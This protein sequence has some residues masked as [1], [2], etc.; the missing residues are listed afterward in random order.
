MLLCSA[1]TSAKYLIDTYYRSLI[2]LGPIT[3]TAADVSPLCNLS[4]NYGQQH[5]R[6]RGVGNV[7]RESLPVCMTRFMSSHAIMALSQQICFKCKPYSHRWSTTNFTAF[8]D[9]SFSLYLLFFS[10]PWYRKAMKLVAMVV[11]IITFSLSEVTDWNTPMGLWPTKWDGIDNIKVGRECGRV[12]LLH[13]GLKK[14]EMCWRNR[15]PKCV[16]W[17]GQCYWYRS[18]R[19][20]P[21][22]FVQKRDQPVTWADQGLA[23]PACHYRLPPRV[24]GLL[25]AFMKPHGE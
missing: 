2:L 15:V 22:E 4:Y 23:G 21:V 7:Q 9:G 12:P 11:D 6:G 10:P 1:A 18:R 3:R 13:C 20:N 17:R 5:L 19:K 24:N 16:S 14:S 8:C 25:Q